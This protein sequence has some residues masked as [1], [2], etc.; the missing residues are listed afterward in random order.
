M[1]PVELMEGIQSLDRVSKLRVVKILVDDLAA[2]EAKDL[3]KDA[4]YEIFT[5]Y[6]NEVAAEL[7]YE[8]LQEHNAAGNTDAT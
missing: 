4:P 5:P 8:S 7:L 2:E 1:I 6:G 3:A